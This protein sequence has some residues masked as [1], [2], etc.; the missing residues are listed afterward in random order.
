MYINKEGVGLKSSY[1]P[2]DIL[3]KNFTGSAHLL[4]ARGQEK[5]M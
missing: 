1:S 5:R 3:R 2:I 4:T